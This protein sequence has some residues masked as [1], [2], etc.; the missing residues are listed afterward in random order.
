MDSSIDLD[1]LSKKLKKGAKAIQ[2]PEY[3]LKNGAIKS[4]YIPDFLN[5][6]IEG[7]KKAYELTD[8]RYEAGNVPAAI[9]TEQSKYIMYE[10]QLGETNVYL[11]DLYMMTGDAELYDIIQAN[12]TAFADCSVYRGGLDMIYGANRY[13]V[14][15]LYDEKN[16]RASHPYYGDATG[17]YASWL[18]T[19][20]SYY[21]ETFKIMVDHL[22]NNAKLQKNMGYNVPRMIDWFNDAGT[23]ELTAHVEC[24]YMMEIRALGIAEKLY[25]GGEYK[26]TAD[27]V[28]GWAGNAITNDGFWYQAYFDDGTPLVQSS[29]TQAAVKNYTMLYGARALTDYYEMYPSNDLKTLMEKF[30]TYLVGEIKNSNFISDVKE[31]LYEENEDGTSGQMSTVNIMASDY[32]FDLYEICSKDI[33][34]TAGVKLL[35][36]WIAQQEKGGFWPQHINKYGYGSNSITAG[37]AAQHLSIFGKCAEITNVL[38]SNKELLEVNAYG[39]E[40]LA[41]WFGRKIY[42]ENNYPDHEVE[43]KLYTGECGDLVT[44]VN[45][46]GY[47]SGQW[48]KTIYV[49]PKNFG[50]IWTNAENSIIW[51]NK[52]VL[53]FTLNQF[54]MASAMRIP[55]DIMNLSAPISATVSSYDSSGITIDFEGEGDFNIIYTGVNNV[56][57]TQYDKTVRINYVDNEYESDSAFYVDLGEIETSYTDIK[58]SAY[59]NSIAY[60]EKSK[61]ISFAD[62]DVFLPQQAITGGEMASLINNALGITMSSNLEKITKQ[63]CTRM[64]LKA[65]DETGLVDSL[66]QA[67][68]YYVLPDT[69]LSS[70]IVQL[71]KQILDLPID[72]SAVTNS[73]E[74]PTQGIYGAEISWTSSDGDVLSNTGEITRPVNNDVK[75]SLCAKISYGSVSATKNFELNVLSLENND[76]YAFGNIKQAM[77]IMNNQCSN[78]EIDIMP[79]RYSDT[80]IGFANEREIIHD[81]RNFQAFI[82]FR[83]QGDILLQNSSTTLSYAAEN[84]FRYTP[85]VVYTF[86]VQVN[87]A[88]GTYSVSVKEK[89]SNSSTVLAKDYALKSGKCSAYKMNRMFV[90]SF[91]QPDNAL[92][93]VRNSCINSIQSDEV[94]SFINTNYVYQSQYLFDDMYMPYGAVSGD[95]SLVSDNGELQGR[96]SNISKLKIYVPLSGTSS[97]LSDYLTQCGILGAWDGD[98]LSRAEAVA[99]VNR[100]QNF[101]GYSLEEA[102]VDMSECKN[103]NFSSISDELL[104]RISKNLHLPTQYVADSGKIY[105]IKWISSN[106]NLVENDGTVHRGD[107]PE[108]VCLNA[109]FTLGDKSFTKSCN[110]TVLPKNIKEK[111]LDDFE[112]YPSYGQSIHGFNGWSLKTA[113]P[114]SSTTTAETDLDDARNHIGMIDRTAYKTPNGTDYKTQ[115]ATLAFEKV[116]ENNLTME[117]GKTYYISMRL[118]NLKF[119]Q[120]R[121]ELLDENSNDLFSFYTAKNSDSQ[122]DKCILRYRASETGGNAYSTF[123]YSGNENK[124]FDLTIAYHKI[125][126]DNDVYQSLC[127]VYLN[128]EK[129]LSDIPCSVGFDSKTQTESGNIS[130]LRIEIP[131]DSEIATWYMDDISLYEPYDISEIS[132]CNNFNL[133]NYNSE[134]LSMVTQNLNL[135]YTYI[136]NGCKYDVIWKSGNDSILSD[137]GIVFPTNTYSRIN[138]NA[139][140]FFT[141]D[142][143]VYFEKDFYIGI[144]G[145]HNSVNED[146]NTYDSDKTID[147]CN[148]WNV[149]SGLNAS[150]SKIVQSNDNKFLEIIRTSTT[151]DNSSIKSEAA[152]KTYDNS[153]LINTDALISMRLKNE[154]NSSLRIEILDTEGNNLIYLESG[155]STSENKDKITAFYVDLESKE[156]ANKSFS[157]AGNEGEWFELALMYH[158]KRDSANIIQ[159]TYDL[160]LNG[161]LIL[162]GIG[163]AFAYSNRTRTNSGNLSQFKIEIPRDS[164]CGRWAIDDLNVYRFNCNY[165]F[166]I[167]GVKFIDRNG[168]LSYI[169]SPGSKI[170]EVRISQL[171]D[172]SN[173]AVVIIANSNSSG[174]V[175]S[176]ECKPINLT[177]KSE[178]FTISAIPPENLADEF[179]SRI[180]LWN[181]FD[182]IKPLSPSILLP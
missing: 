121:I 81:Y 43:T 7:L 12:A 170:S 72:K 109:V 101:D 95:T 167:S 49:Q 156:R 64:V 164:E 162:D 136:E 110:I 31:D 18:I 141:E 181:N 65:L 94:K 30:G 115:R 80:F 54:E 1:G 150:T 111:N 174:T 74:L 145:N 57:I 55:V 96:N 173:N 52:T 92:K 169:N 62:E 56:K 61:I 78:F 19:G 144:I 35:S 20:N 66:A 86:S 16:F 158:K 118:K 41:M 47:D 132:N 142:K 102:T 112:N 5:D 75:V 51:E 70:E 106:N 165:D 146:F 99:L 123:L 24:R 104:T 37:F 107:K 48:E 179:N 29:Q 4:T 69:T 28:I 71:N 25:G 27:N 22:V 171:T 33:Y 85:G 153:S 21:E 133:Q 53:S 60:A 120:L 100:L 178:W 73:F 154:Y 59:K 34:L 17:Q 38:S 176:I 161:E 83:R 46:S 172:T 147:G 128:G 32:L 2:S 126:G 124:W 168:N 160:Y 152:V 103:F 14:G 117:D 129:M 90:H 177:Q 130:A 166:R 36:Y 125:L 148:A 84:S 139:K 157:Y 182:D 119:S 135:P 108:K 116:L 45:N 140:L 67:E 134:N 68:Q 114:S 88:N 76:M 58:M 131:R 137:S 82:R 163:C 159:S 180:M 175:S 63:D 89:G 87:E 97:T 98:Y 10:V 113:T 105:N 138:L 42:L 122:N 127:D 23:P 149:I 91:Y 26:S 44:V 3:Y 143:S 15:R 93:V 11:T 40:L 79:L 13:R 39:K 155:K 151:A 50:G 6:T 8:S 77:H 9:D